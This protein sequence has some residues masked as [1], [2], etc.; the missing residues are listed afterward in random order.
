MKI[1][2]GFVSNSSSSSFVIAYKGDGKP[3]KKCGMDATDFLRTFL[4]SLNN[5]DDGD[6]SYKEVTN[7]DD[8][9]DNFG[10]DEHEDEEEIL[11]AKEFLKKDYIIGI[12]HV[13]Y[14]SEELFK[15]MIE[16]AKKGVDLEIIRDEN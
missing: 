15:N 10:L 9:I 4:E 5:N 7:L 16:S 6:S 3:C 2:N 11:E 1:R 12:A 13:G 14:G 8:Y